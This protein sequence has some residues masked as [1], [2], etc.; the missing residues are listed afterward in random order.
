MLHC[1]TMFQNCPR[2]GHVTAFITLK[3]RTYCKV[4]IGYLFQLCTKNVETNKSLCLSTSDTTV[5]K[6]WRKKH[7]GS[8]SSRIMHRTH[9]LWDGA[10]GL[11]TKH[12]YKCKTCVLGT[13]VDI[14]SLNVLFKCP[15]QAPK[16][17]HSHGYKT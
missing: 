7:E 10:A 8:H 11:I 9:V 14:I 6:G 4:L 5:P 1:C 2:D 17:Q 15:Q 3:Y 12:T 13:V 16:S